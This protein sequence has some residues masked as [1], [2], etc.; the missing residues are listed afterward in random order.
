MTLTRALTVWAT[1]EEIE[2]IKAAALESG[3]RPGTWARR[4][5]AAAVGIQLAPE[6]LKGNQNPKGTPK[7]PRKW[8]GIKPFYTY[9]GKTMTLAEWAKVQGLPAG[10]LRQRVG[11]YGWPLERA[12]T[13]RPHARYANGFHGR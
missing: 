6:P 4:Q 3:M 12:L 5:L 11:R 1:D 9:R 10:M 13:E 2:A 8:M 7:K